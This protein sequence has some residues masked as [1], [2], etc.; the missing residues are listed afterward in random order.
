MKNYENL[1]VDASKVWFTSDP[2]FNHGNIIKYCH[3]PF[4]CDRDKMAL[5]ENGGVWHQGIW[6][7]EFASRH[8]ISKESVR[9]MDDELIN[10]T[11]ECVQ[12]D[13]ILWNLGDF[14][15]PSRYDE[16]RYFYET[17]K[18]YRDRINCRDVRILWGNHDNQNLIANLFKQNYMLHHVSYNNALFCMC[19]YAMATWNKSHRK[20]INLYGHSHGQAEDWMNSHM[21]GRR[22]LDVGVDNAFRLFGKFRPISLKEIF[23]HFETSK[24]FSMNQE[25]PAGLTTPPEN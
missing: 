2:H 11:N 16:D 6:K 21:P 7:G 25:C 5:E 8:K 9:I 10:Q 14:A 17:C 12:E 4:L 24:G 15:F 20:S 1:D 13:D 19:H 22:S 3:R 23:E 18:H